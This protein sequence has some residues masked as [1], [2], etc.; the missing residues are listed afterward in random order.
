MLAALLPGPAPATAAD[1]S[2]GLAVE[3][4]RSFVQ[5]GLH[6]R[7]DAAAQALAVLEAGTGNTQPAILADLRRIPPDLFDADRR[8]AAVAAAL[9]Q[10]GDVARPAEAAAALKQILSQPRY[11]GLHAQ[12]SPWN[13]FWN[14]LFTQL[15]GWIANLQVGA[16]PAWVLYS[17][18]GA[19]LLL[20][21]GVALLI[22]R[23]GWTRAGRALEVARE[24][25]VAPDRDR[26]SEAD[27]AAAAG[28][29]SAALRSLV[30]GVATAVSGRP[31]W[32]TSPL[33]VRELFRDSGE[34]ERLRPL[35]LAFEASAYGRRPVG[36]SDYRRALEL[37][38]PFRER[39]EPAA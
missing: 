17:L 21:L 12:D 26:F 11:A 20:T 2:Y 10:P 36:E 16:I 5:E 28:D 14:W 33:T 32:D 34:L 27:A 30:A 25:R 24:S 19:G 1:R 6:G 29:Y 13:R 31:F 38:E 15:F 18:L 39:R 4:A 23:S 9:G 22:A 8:L 35:L 3:Q 37:A 7:P